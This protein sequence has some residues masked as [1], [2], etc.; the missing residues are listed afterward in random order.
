M[1]STTQK[2]EHKHIS[3]GRCQDT[4]KLIKHQILFRKF[5]ENVFNVIV[6]STYTVS[7]CRVSQQGPKTTDHH[8]RGPRVMVYIVVVN[9]NTLLNLNNSSYLTFILYIL[10]YYKQYLNWFLNI[11]TITLRY[12][13]YID[14]LFNSWSGFWLK[15]NYYLDLIRPNQYKRE[16]INI[17]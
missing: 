13:W 11:V 1:L 2:R 9:K 16:I 15:I 6:A 7:E 3:I 5:F 17:S 10:I 14:I 4:V 8:W 12:G